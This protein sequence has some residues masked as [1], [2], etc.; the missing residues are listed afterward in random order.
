MA[1]PAS[2][3]TPLRM[4]RQA[5]KDCG[6]LQTGEEPTGEVLADALERINDLINFWQT[7]GLKL[8]L[9]SVQSITPVA[10]TSLYTL[11]PAGAILAVK[12]TR[13]LEGWRSTATGDRTPLNPLSWNEYHRLGN[14]TTPGYTNSYFVDK[15][16]ANLLVRF[17][18]V[19]DAAVA[20]GTFELLIQAQATAPTELDE[21]IL[22]PVE[23]YLALRWALADEL[24]SGQ[25]ALIMDRCA[26]K[27]AFYLQAL[28]DWDVE[29][30]P[31][32]FQPDSLASGLQPSR[33]R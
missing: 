30:A 12:P 14:L 2:L 23:W 15:Q 24:A 28:Q 16:A 31:T 8:W 13:V 10:G 26:G 19:P 11:G 20:T 5:L 22:F 9:N 4:V 17:W 29:D 3:Y 21:T 18:P 25:P 7:Q 6:R 1:A 27:A 32:R 33:F